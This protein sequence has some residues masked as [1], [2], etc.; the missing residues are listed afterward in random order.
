MQY[1]F[2]TYLGAFSKIVNVLTCIGQLFAYTSNY[3]NKNK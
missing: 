3:V 1:T 2:N